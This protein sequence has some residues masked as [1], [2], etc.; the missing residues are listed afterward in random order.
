MSTR[1]IAC[2]HCGC[3]GMLDVHCVNDVVPK[4]RVFKHLGHNPFSGHLHYRCP[5]C[6]TVLLV[7]P[8]AALGKNSLN[9][10]PGKRT[11]LQN[12]KTLTAIRSKQLLKIPA[13][14][15]SSARNWTIVTG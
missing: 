1:D 15:S 12:W 4:D 10:F 9:G 7:E 2:L 11:D 13:E 8:V 14:L 6:K 3:T 5:V